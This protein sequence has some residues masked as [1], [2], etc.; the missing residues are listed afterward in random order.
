MKY[1]LPEKNPRI[2]REGLYQV[3]PLSSLAAS[4][5]IWK[6]TRRIGGKVYVNCMIQT[7]A[8]SPETVCTCGIAEPTMNAGMRDKALVEHTL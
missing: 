5:C 3:S 8:T 2:Q 6:P 1:H 4:S 7:A